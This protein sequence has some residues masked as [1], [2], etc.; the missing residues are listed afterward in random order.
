MNDFLHVTDEMNC[1]TAEAARESWP[2]I[3]R[4]LPPTRPAPTVLARQRLAHA[5][6]FDEE[7]L[8][9]KKAKP[10]GLMGAEIWVKIADTPP[11]DRSERAFWPWTPTRRTWRNTPARQPPRKPTPCSAGSTR[12]ATK[13][14]R[15]K[16][17][18][19]RSRH[20]APFAKILPAGTDPFAYGCGLSRSRTPPTQPQN[21]FF[22]LV[23]AWTAAAAVNLIALSVTTC[24]CSRIE[25][26][27]TPA[28]DTTLRV[29]KAQGAVKLSA[30]RVP[31][32]VPNRIDNPIHSYVQTHILNMQHFPRLAWL[33]H[34]DTICTF[35]GLPLG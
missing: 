25:A 33:R 28:R 13:A 3:R 11:A 21:R 18:V 30:D 16:P 23:V 7:E 8:P 32:Y 34:V 17:P 20:D 24:G 14:R 10:T 6:W 22:Q 2:Y 35:C 27:D 4:G 26:S 1:R 19:R 5:S 9:T 12:G 15:A 31:S 29:A